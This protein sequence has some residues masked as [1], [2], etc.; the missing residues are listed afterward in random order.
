MAF[1]KLL[2]Q[3]RHFLFIIMALAFTT[4]AKAQTPS[5]NINSTN[6]TPL[7]PSPAAESSATIYTFPVMV[8]IVFGF[9]GGIAVIIG[10][11]IAVYN[12]MTRSAC[13]LKSSDKE[14]MRSNAET[15]LFA[16]VHKAQKHNL[17]EFL[18]GV[19]DRA[20][21]G[22]LLI[23]PRKLLGCFKRKSVAGFVLEETMP[24]AGLPAGSPTRDRVEAHLL[25]YRK[26]NWRGHRLHDGVGF[27][28][29]D[30]HPYAIAAAR[31]DLRGY[32]EITINAENLAYYSHIRG[33][34]PYMQT[35]AQTAADG[36]KSYLSSDQTRFY[37]SFGRHNMGI[38]FYSV[39]TPAQEQVMGSLVGLFA[40]P[41]MPQPQAAIQTSFAQGFIPPPPT[42]LYE[43][44]LPSDAWGGTGIAIAMPPS[45]F[46]PVG[47]IM[48]P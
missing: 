20:N 6:S 9:I 30:S 5:P 23:Y 48:M 40:P 39:F 33:L 45:A 46:N 24:V 47:T 42:R 13:P 16:K 31:G 44:V 37:V 8:S 14:L 19:F 38:L 28:D 3:W 22:R 2:Y 41:A 11:G 26:Y 21:K 18:R 1:R 27:T 25:H 10:A 36:W 15:W 32:E 29:I 35:F 7:P 12:V 43:H 4:N 17:E 34:Y